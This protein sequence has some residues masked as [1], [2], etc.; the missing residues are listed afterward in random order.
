MLQHPL[1]KVH[2]SVLRDNTTEAGTFRQVWSASSPGPVWWVGRLTSY[3]TT[4][5]R[6]AS[7]VGLEATANIKLKEVADVSF[8]ADATSVIPS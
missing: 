2:L 5:K 1:A 8:A 3:R 4:L 7:L 6:L